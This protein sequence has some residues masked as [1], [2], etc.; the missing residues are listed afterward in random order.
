MP[1]GVADA[2]AMA[3]GISPDAKISGCTRTYI[4]D[5]VRLLLMW[6]IHFV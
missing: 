1:I 2:D 6:I 3:K 4:I 5:W